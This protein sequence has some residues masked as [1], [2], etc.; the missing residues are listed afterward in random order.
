[1]RFPGERYVFMSKV[2]SLKIGI[3][4]VACV[5]FVYTTYWLI[6]G[7]IWDSA[8][9]Y[10]YAFYQATIKAPWRIIVFYASEL[11][12]TVGIPF[13]S[14]SGFLAVFLAF[15]FLKKGKDMLPS[16][17]KKIGYVLLFEGFY[18]L[19]LIPSFILGFTYPIVNDYYWYFDTQ[20]VIPLIEG[21]VLCVEV[22]L[23]PILLFMLRKEVK[24]YFSSKA[25]SQEVTKLAWT[26]GLAYLFVFWFN[27]S[28]QW[29]L[30]VFSSS[31]EILF[32]FMNLVGFVVTVYGLFAILLFWFVSLNKL[33][34][35]HLGVV[36]TALGGYFIFIIL[37]YVVAGGYSARPLLWYYFIIPH[38]LDL[39][40]A[41]L[42]FVG[43]PLLAKR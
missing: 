14:V 25:S 8:I 9:L 34:L 21:M 20:R 40:C 16:A 22:S 17:G 1:M 27:Y 19:A 13:R 42:I 38:N 7:F 18:W 3:I 23:I 31:I 12:G 28:M 15:V 39:W 30:T 41:S 32:D 6:R 29:I 11:I 2:T 10:E 36:L 24:R 4:I 26:A 37:H 35:R 43:V 33:S 5:Y